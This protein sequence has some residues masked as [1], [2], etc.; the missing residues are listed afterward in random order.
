MGFWDAA[1]DISNI[2]SA[3]SG[4]MSIHYKQYVQKEKNADILQ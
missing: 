2:N 4:V 3:H 1:H